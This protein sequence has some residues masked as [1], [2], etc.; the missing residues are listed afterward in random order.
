MLGLWG[1]GCV[2]FFSIL[3]EWLCG[4]R[5]AAGGCGTWCVTTY[6]AR[7]TDMADTSVPLEAIVVAA[8]VATLQA[9]A[10]SPLPGRIVAFA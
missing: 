9:G 2:L 8:N 7:V 4:G 1:G 6:I 5:L 3:G 10:F